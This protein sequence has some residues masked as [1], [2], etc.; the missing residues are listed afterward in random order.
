M[1]GK[2]RTHPYHIFVL[3]LWDE[4]TTKETIYIFAQL[5]FNITFIYSFILV[6]IGLCC[7]A[8]AF[9]S[10]GE[11]ELFSRCGVRASHYSGFS[12]CR[13]QE[14]GTWAS[15]VA[16]WGLSSWGAQA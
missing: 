15:V 3:I 13:A 8:W 10:C 11:Q 6:I 14:L 9:S 4:N 5:F 2:K 16:A 7:C 1:Q 12:G